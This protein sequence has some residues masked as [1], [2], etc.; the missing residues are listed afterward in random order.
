MMEKSETLITRVERINLLMDLYGNLLTEKQRRFLELHYCEDLSFGEIATQY[1]VSR[2]AIYDA[3]KHALANLEHYE[4][5]LSLL[6]KFKDS[7]AIS[8]FEPQEKT[9]PP[10]S[11]S[12]SEVTTALKQ[13]QVKLQRQNIIYNVGR[14]VHDISRIIDLA[15]EKQPGKTG[16][17]QKTK[18]GL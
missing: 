1:N 17:A 2:Q 13:L 14:I 8:P 12:L 15:E 6:N 18:A 7:E 3:V 5:T 11:P 4:K 10:P 9:C 16:E